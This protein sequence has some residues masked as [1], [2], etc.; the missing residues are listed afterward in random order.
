M[1]AITDPNTLVDFSSEVKKEG[2]SIGL[3]PTM[4]A[5]HDGHLSLIK[6]SIKENDKTVVSIFINPLQ[7]D[8]EADLK[9]YPKRI[10]EDKSKL[11]PLDIAV[12]FEPLVKDFY[13]KEPSV[14]VYFGEMEKTLEGQFRPGHFGGVGVVVSKLFHLAQPD[15]AYFGLKDLQQFLL[16]RKM[17]EDLSFQ[18]EIVGVETYRDKSGLAMSSRNQRLSNEGK[19][20]AT[21]IFKG[22]AIG[23]EM[24]LQ[25]KNFQLIKQNIM[26]FFNSIS[27]LE[28]EY[29]AFVDG[30]NLKTLAS[31]KDVNALAICFAGHVEGVRLIDNLYLRLKER[32]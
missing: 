23:R 16:I 22:L 8:K 31:Y 27:G 15:R 5:L 28:V 2:L 20:I 1:R 24:I 18:V 29:V 11:D 9:S 25:G 30:S 26:A 19:E 3:V 21:S 13:A 14:H 12:V 32:S 7:F 10:E 17:V 6:R 4:G